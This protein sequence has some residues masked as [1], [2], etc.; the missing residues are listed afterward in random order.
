[1]T[2]NTAGGM[3]QSDLVRHT[4]PN[5]TPL[6]SMPQSVSIGDDNSCNGAF[7]GRYKA[8]DP[9]M[10]QSLAKILV[11]AI[12]STKHRQPLIEPGIQNGLSAYLAGILAELD[13]LS[14]FNRIGALCCDF[15]SNILWSGPF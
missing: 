15:I 7:V 12:F 6:S 9:I 3:G 2:K 13:C 14:N 8:K 1:M 4:H 11:H 5:A 10:P